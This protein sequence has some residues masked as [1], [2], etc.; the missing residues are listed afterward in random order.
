MKTIPGDSPLSP[1]SPVAPLF[2]RLHKG[3]SV[4]LTEAQEAGEDE[5]VHIPAEE[6]GARDSP[7]LI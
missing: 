4:R 5:K 6:C 1:F 2:P 7:P 3:V